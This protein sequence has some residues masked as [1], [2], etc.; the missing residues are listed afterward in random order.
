MFYWVNEED[1]RASETKNQSKN[2][3]LNASLF[4]GSA[5]V[6]R[7]RGAILNGFDIQA[8]SLQSSDRT[9]ASATRAFDSNFDLFHA[10]FNGLFSTLLSCH[11]SSKGSALSATLVTAC[12]R[13]RPAQSLTLG[14]RNGYLGVVKGRVDV[15]DTVCHVTT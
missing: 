6:V 15:R 4:S 2:G 1:L 9:L 14:V 12:A 13:T 7:N 11:L 5:T 3:E 10:E 8:R